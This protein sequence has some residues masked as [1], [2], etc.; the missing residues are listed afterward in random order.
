MIARIVA[1][2]PMRYRRGADASLDRPAHVRAASALVWVGARLCVVQDDA[3]FLGV[4]DPATGLVDDVPLA[5]GP[6]GARTFDVA[7]GNKRDKPDLEAAFALDDRL[8][9]LGSGGPIAARQVVVTWAPGAAPDTLA[10]PRLFDALARALL[11]AGA[12]L[13]LEGATVVG[14]EVWLANRGGDHG[15]PDAIARL[16]RDVFRRVLADEA[17]APPP[18]RV[19][20]LALGAMGG[21]ALHVTEIRAAGDRVWY[22]AAAEATGSFYDDG[23]VTGS[24]IGVLGGAHAELRG[25]KLEGLA[26]G[27]PTY[28]CVDADDPDRPADLLELA[29]D[30]T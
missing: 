16:P 18:P 15:S 1:R 9:A 10:R 24:I 21:V 25:D 23:A 14:D 11:P 5:A 3:A 28:A 22:T 17:F 8:I 20:A 12:A 2:R 13:N 30:L 19:D 26:I 6:G 7:R 27:A 29:L 4:V